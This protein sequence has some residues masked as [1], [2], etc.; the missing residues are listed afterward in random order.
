MSG[1]GMMSLGSSMDTVKISDVIVDDVDTPASAGYQL[2]STG[3]VNSI[4][5]AGGTVKLGNWVV[6]NSS[7]AKY[8]S[9]AA[10]NSGTLSS[11]T[12]G[13]WQALSLSRTWTRIRTAGVGVTSAN[14]T[15]TIRNAATGTNLT[16]AIIVLNAEIP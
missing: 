12:T 15:V 16:S 9:F 6:P 4:T 13:T 8:E 1:V 2:A 5:N 10:L 7:A 14:I 11:G 3:I